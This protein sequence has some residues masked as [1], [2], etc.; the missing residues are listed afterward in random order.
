MVSLMNTHLFLKF[1]LFTWIRRKFKLFFFI[2]LFFKFKM[3]SA[4]LL[5]S[6]LG[7]LLSSQGVLAAPQQVL[8]F[9]NASP[10]E[11]AQI[12]AGTYGEMFDDAPVYNYNY[13]VKIY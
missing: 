5:L 9:G 12:R 7:V 11:I 6:P 3:Y 10:D 1:V 8:G 13:K 4:V 2:K